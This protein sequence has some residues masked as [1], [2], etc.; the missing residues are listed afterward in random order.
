MCRT[1]ALLRARVGLQACPTPRPPT[2]NSQGIRL[3]MIL[4]TGKARIHARLKECAFSA[5]SSQYCYR[6]FP[7]VSEPYRFA[8]W[9]VWQ[10]PSKTH[11]GSAPA[12]TSP[13]PRACGKAP[14]AATHTRGC[15]RAPQMDPLAGQTRDSLRQSSS[16]APSQCLSDRSTSARHPKKARVEWRAGLRT[17]NPKAYPS[18]TLRPGTPCGTSS[19]RSCKRVC[20]Y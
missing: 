11:C 5:G 2:Y 6:S 19:T 17:L 1:K 14:A 7:S 9:K 10:S 4:R 15:G 8:G 12:A 13:V 3:S 16:G 20:V 18:P